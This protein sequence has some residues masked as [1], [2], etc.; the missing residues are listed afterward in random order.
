V[1]AIVRDS[2]GYMSILVRD[3]A[4]DG[5]ALASRSAKLSEIGTYMTAGNLELLIATGVDAIQFA[6]GDGQMVRP[7][8]C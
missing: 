5:R 7:F 1:L 4:L 6:N 2:D 8:I 3:F